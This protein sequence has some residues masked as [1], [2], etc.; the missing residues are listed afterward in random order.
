MKI[1]YMAGHRNGELSLNDELEHCLSIL[2]LCKTAKQCNNLVIRETIFEKVRRNY[3]GATSSYTPLAPLD[4]ANETV[5]QDWNTNPGWYIARNVTNANGVGYKP[6]VYPFKSAADF[7]NVLAVDPS[8]W[9]SKH[10]SPPRF[11]GADIATY[12]TIPS[13]DAGTIAYIQEQKGIEDANN[14]A[15]HANKLKNVLAQAGKVVVDVATGNFVKAGADV[16]STAAAAANNG[17]GG[18]SSSGGGNTPNNV[19]YPPPPPL[20]PAKPLPVWVV[21]TVGVIVVGGVLY[22][23]FK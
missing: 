4:F 21:P 9:I 1:S 2:E 16:V 7:S 5:F 18:G 6:M 13:L 8:A 11:T 20:P 10:G 22:F 17:S 23:I 14:A 12:G 3:I 19:I 15:Y